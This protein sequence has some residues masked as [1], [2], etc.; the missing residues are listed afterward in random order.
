M[1]SSQANQRQLN[2]KPS[3]A[4]TILY[5]ATDRELLMFHAAA[6]RAVGYTLHVV[7]TVDDALN[8][9]AQATFNAVIIGQLPVKERRRLGEALRQLH[10]RP[11]I[12]ML[13]EVSIVQA[14]HADA[15]LNV[16]G[17][18]EDLVRTI[19]YLLTGHC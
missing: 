5:L 3:V 8:K 4:P 19:R 18:S 16:N 11:Q 1:G 14:E 17:H 6:L 7:G 15:V 9:A 2:A 12:V 10:P 13:Y